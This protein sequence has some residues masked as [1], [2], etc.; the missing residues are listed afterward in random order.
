[1]HKLLMRWLSPNSVQ[2]LAIETR[3]GK[4]FQESMMLW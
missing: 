1:M 3:D 2:M 4:S